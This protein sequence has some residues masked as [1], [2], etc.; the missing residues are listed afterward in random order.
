VSEDEVQV[1]VTE[2]NA[3]ET[4]GLVAAFEEVVA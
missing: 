2:T 1:C 4:D 3:D